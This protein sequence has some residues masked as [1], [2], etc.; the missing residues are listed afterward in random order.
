MDVPVIL[1]EVIEI[2]IRL[3]RSIVWRTEN[4]VIDLQVSDD[5]CLRAAATLVAASRT[6]P[7]LEDFVQ[8]Q[9]AVAAAEIVRELLQK[10]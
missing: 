1:D 3:K 10:E 6:P 8:S 7:G 5:A 9:V 2:A 4:G